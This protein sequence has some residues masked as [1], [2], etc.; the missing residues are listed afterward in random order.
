MIS[1]PIRL[2][3]VRMES[4]TKLKRRSRRIALSYIPRSGCRAKVVLEFGT[5]LDHLFP[6]VV[7]ILALCLASLSVW[8]KVKNARLESENCRLQSENSALKHQVE[9]LMTKLA[10]YENAKQSTVQGDEG[11]FQK[12]VQTVVGLGVP[13]LVL[14]VAVSTSGYAGAAALTAALATLGGPFGMLAGIGTLLVLFPLSKALQK[15]GLSRISQ[16]VVRRLVSQGDSPENI[17][18]KIQAIPR[19]AITTELRSK[20]ENVL[21]EA[22]A[23]KPTLGETA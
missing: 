22:E 9:E 6:V 15:F 12:A 10:V 3:R 16:A 1:G 7:T 8:L 18:S 20:L 23:A 13:G 17:R 4:W 21:E 2:S 19:W 11:I 5:V 14:L